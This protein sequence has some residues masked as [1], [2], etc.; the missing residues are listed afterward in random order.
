MLQTIYLGENIGDFYYSKESYRD[1]LG[2]TVIYNIMWHNIT[3]WFNIFF[4]TKLWK[5][6]IKHKVTMAV[7]YEEEPHGSDSPFVSM[8]Q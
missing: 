8:L 5:N 6:K 2:K 1:F 4:H 7:L 3:A